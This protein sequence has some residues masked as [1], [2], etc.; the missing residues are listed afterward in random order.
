MP[1]DRSSDQHDQHRAQQCSGQPAAGRPPEGRPRGAGPHGGAGRF[2][3]PVEPPQRRRDRRFP[4]RGRRLRRRRQSGGDIVVAPHQS[5]PRV[6]DAAVSGSAKA[7]RRKGGK[8][9]IGRPYN[10]SRGPV[11]RR[12]ALSRARPVSPL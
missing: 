3:G 12:I 4:F 9:G 5:S 6:G 11:E 10:E 1:G 8:N 7:Q 2:V